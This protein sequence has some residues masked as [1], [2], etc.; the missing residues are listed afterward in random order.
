M[1]KRRILAKFQVG[2]TAGLDSA[3]MSQ[4]QGQSFIYIIEM[5]RNPEYVPNDFNSSTTKSKKS[6]SGLARVL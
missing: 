2:S 4:C 5:L 6:I 1:A 3:L